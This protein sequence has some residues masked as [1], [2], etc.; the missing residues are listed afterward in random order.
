MYVKQNAI[1]MINGC[2]VKRGL[3]YEKAINKLATRRQW[4][5][6][7]EHNRWR[8]CFINYIVTSSVENN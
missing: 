5:F 4:C 8:I 7:I 2:I 3:G 6:E 1:I